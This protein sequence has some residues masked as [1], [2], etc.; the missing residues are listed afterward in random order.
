MLKKDDRTKQMVYYQARLRHD[1]LFILRLTDI[2]FFYKAGIGTYI[3]GQT[4]TPFAAGVSKAIDTAIARSLD[5]HVMGR[6]PSPISGGVIKL[7]CPADI[8]QM[9]MNS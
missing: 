1:Y 3:S 4:A 9:G 6:S 8:N 2:F 5:S 7:R